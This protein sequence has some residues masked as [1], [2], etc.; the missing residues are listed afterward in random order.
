MFLKK[1]LVE[2]SPFKVTTRPIHK[3]TVIVPAE[4]FKITSEKNASGCII[5]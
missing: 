2:Q 4:K 1:A 3:I 5:K